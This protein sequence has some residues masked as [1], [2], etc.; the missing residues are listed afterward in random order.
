MIKV[1]SK[2]KIEKD[3]SNYGK[4]R[5]GFQ[6]F[7]KD[8]NKENLK[9]HYKNNKE[10]Y[11]QRNKNKQNI[12]KTKL[13]EYLHD[14]SCIDCGNSDHRVLEFDHLYDKKKDISRAIRDW[15]WISV[16]EEIKKCEIVCCNC[17]R[18]RTLQR[19]NS[20]RTIA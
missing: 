16:L 3:I 13:L 20:Y 8:C 9:Q 1:C 4:K 6:T 14:K 19:A 10:T 17:H 15:S 12:N 11:V 5:N 18:I 2:C 7:C